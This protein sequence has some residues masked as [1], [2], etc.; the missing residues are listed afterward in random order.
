MDAQSTNKSNESLREVYARTPLSA[1]PHEIRLLHLWSDE[2][3]G[4]VICTLTKASMA[5]HEDYQALSYAWGDP[6]ITRPILV[7]DELTPKGKEVAIAEVQVT[8]NLEAALRA[9]RVEN[10]CRVLWVDALCI[11]QQD[12]IEKSEQ[13]QMMGV[14][15]R[16]AVHTLVWLG[17][18][19]DGAEDALTL[20][21][22]ISTNGMEEALEEQNRNAWHDMPKVLQ[23][24]W[25]SRVWIVQEF[26]LSAE[27]SIFRCGNVTVPWSTLERFKATY[28]AFVEEAQQ[29]GENYYQGI[30][31]RCGANQ[32]Q[33][34]QLLLHVVPEIRTMNRL[35]ISTADSASSEPREHIYA[36]MGLIGESP[37]MTAFTPDY[38]SPISKV[39]ADFVRWQI[40]NYKP[41]SIILFKKPRTRDDLPS[42]VP[43]FA[44]KEIA[45][46]T[47]AL[48]LLES[49]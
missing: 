4:M 32:I 35:L 41:L 18:G 26:V 44:S 39:Y 37:R 19:Q 13:V 23:C 5:D 46:R 48:E 40:E 49:N 38:T 24:D 22:S 14:I 42:W 6:A 17:D 15:Y 45:K 16:S 31:S 3:G 36:L 2:V 25:W 47:N 33:Q 43:D 11:N 21:E 34:L 9:L 27:E 10:H 29:Y 1:A 7:A 12:G 8:T 28:R 20:V 30:D